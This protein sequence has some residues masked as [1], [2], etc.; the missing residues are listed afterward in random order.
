MVNVVTQRCYLCLQ[1]L[2]AG[3]KK[4]LEHCTGHKRKR[5]TGTVEIEG[6]DELEAEEE[7]RLVLFREGRDKE[8]HEARHP[9]QVEAIL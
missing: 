2:T 5:V 7:E 4:H 8:Q 3:H 1:V 6:L 9:A